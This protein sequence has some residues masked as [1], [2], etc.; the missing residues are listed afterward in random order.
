[1]DRIVLNK[2]KPKLEFKLN[3]EDSYLLLQSVS[4]TSPKNGHNQWTNF[5]S[6]VKLIVELKYI[7]YV[8]AEGRFIDERE[9]QFPI[10]FLPDLYQVQPFFHLNALIKN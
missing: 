4:V 3:S 7:V 8:D 10:H 9:K 2:N 6:K 5:V 1:M